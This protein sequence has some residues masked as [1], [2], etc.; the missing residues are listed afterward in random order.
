VAVQ[1]IDARCALGLVVLLLAA[2]EAAAQQI[3]VTAAKCAAEVR[4]VARD[5]P[6]SEVL[7]RLARELDF[8]LRFE[9]HAD[10][11]ITFDASRKPDELLRLI[12]PG[13]NIAITQ[14]RDPGCGGRK[15]VAKV[16]VLPSG[17]ANSPRQ[18][19]S[20]T[21]PIDEP[22]DTPARRGHGVR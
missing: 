7:A 21:G 14:T 3:E 22:A 4:L 5:A 18:P 17:T 1:V 19:P 2:G 13:E 10:P 9:A 11:R 20:A 6:L 12:A 16:W 15:R 8:Q